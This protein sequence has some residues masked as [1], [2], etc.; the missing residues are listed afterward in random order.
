MM[1]WRLPLR[2]AL[3]NL[4]S[5]TGG[6][7]IF[8]V[9]LILG[10]A[11]IASVGSLSQAVEQGLEEEGQPL[12]GGDVEFALIHRQL[13]DEQRREISS[14][15]D[16]STV[17][18]LRAMASSA[19][20]RALVEVKA[21]D[22]RYPLY[23]TLELTPATA[24]ADILAIRN[25]RHGVAVDPLL[26]TR[27][28]LEVGDPLQVGDLEFD[29]RAAIRTEPDRVSDGFILGPR[30]LM[31]GAG[32]D[33]TGLVKPGSLLTWRYRLK[34]DRPELLQSI[35]ERLK[36]QFPDAGWRVRLRDAAAPGVARYVER[37]TLFLTL[38][39]LT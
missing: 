13:S 12:L 30:V 18:T 16:I 10:V 15:G 20:Q 7:R 2:I 24:L 32:L 5:G 34:L 3:R 1:G 14:H 19:G 26:L 23:G 36:A 38:V 9:C 4:R 39:G 8:L 28:D 27:L 22:D 35:A 11:A 31:T 37:L 17:A 25:G 6:F 33:A 29:V 21:V